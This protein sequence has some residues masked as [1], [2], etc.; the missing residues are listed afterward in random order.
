MAIA[1]DS[2][3]SPA[4]L[5]AFVRR[6]P[7]DQQYILNQILPDRVDEVLEAEFSEVTFTARAAKARAWDAPPMPGRRDSFTVSK[8]KLPAVS[9]M[10]GRGER[11]RLELER[12]RAGGQSTSAIVNAIYDDTQNNTEAVL[13]RVE[14]MRGDLLADGK[15][16]FPEMNNMEADFGVPGSHIVSASTVWTDHANADILTDIRAWNRTYR[17]SNGFNFG[18]MI[19]S[20]DR[21]YD[22]LQNEDIRDLWAGISG[23]ASVVTLDQLNQTLQANRLPQVLFT[24]DAQ[25]VDDADQAV[26][27][28]PAD[29]VIF[30]PPPGLELGYTQWGMT[31][32]ALELQN[33]GVQIEPSPAGMVAVVDKDVRPPYRESAYVDAT[34]MPVLSRPK[35]L[36][37]ADV[38]A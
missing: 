5:T 31:A 26:N 28:L 21:L 18:G 12:F 24:Y 4:E 15:V 22:M 25:V 33:S 13:R 2:Y 10:L 27:I 11:D 3:V 37:V 7:I 19:L 16:T 9:Q 1:Y 32:T 20:E 30:V 35:G 23:P 8:V 29:K 14:V 34:A 38:A 6:V 17:N 36:F